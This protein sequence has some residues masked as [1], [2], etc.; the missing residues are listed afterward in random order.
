MTVHQ[1][2]KQSE[3]T[4]PLASV[5]SEMD[6]K[7]NY[8][9]LVNT[10]TNTVTKQYVQIGTPTNISDITIKS[11]LKYGDIIVVAGV[12]QVAEGQK[13]KVLAN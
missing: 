7:K 13:V 5:A 2:N 8:V 12:Q 1:P 10:T 3:I 6:T 9:W 4:I 11:G